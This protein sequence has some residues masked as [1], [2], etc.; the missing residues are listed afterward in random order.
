MSDSD[1]LVL[2]GGPAG[3]AH[4]FWRLRQNPDL[5]LNVLEAGARPGG[6]VRST[7]VDGH[8]LELGPQALR[9]TDE[10]DDIVEALDLVDAVHAAKGDA[11]SRW[12][13][14]GGKL[15]AAPK[16]LISALTSPLLSPVAKIRAVREMSIRADPEMPDDESLASFIERRFGPAVVPLVAAAVQGIFAGDAHVLEAASTFP[17]LVDAE[18]EYGSVL[19]GMKAKAK[20]AR[21]A[22]SGAPREPRPP[23]VTFRDGLQTVTNRLHKRL[24]DRVQLGAEI[25]R[26]S[27]DGTRYRVDLAS[28]VIWSAAELVLATPAHVTAR[29]LESI[30]DESSAALAAIP[31]GDVVSVYFSCDADAVGRRGQGFGCLLDPDEPGP[32]LGILYPSALFPDHAP[33]DRA[34]FRVMMGG[35]RDPQIVGRTDEELIDHAAKAMRRYPQI[36]AHLKTLHI[37]RVSRAIPQYVRGHGARVRVARRTLAESHPR[38]QLIGNSYDNVALTA[39]LAAPSARAPE[40]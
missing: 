22:R 14:R 4:A 40:S 5:D 23:L 18:R 33:P 28:G 15:I 27:R 35:A 9:P 17:F 16:G 10:L 20:A 1:V 30:C 11:K 31:F 39:Q 21:E 19:K 8:L 25:V 12:I 29:L 38:L 2:G 24:G 37:E 32:V 7:R 13:G 3:L 34:L 36:D 6:W 26:V